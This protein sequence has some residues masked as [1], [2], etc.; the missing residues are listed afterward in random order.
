MEANELLERCLTFID[1]M[2]SEQG[3]IDDDNLEN[4]IITYLESLKKDTK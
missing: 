4:D 3:E 1:W 2:K